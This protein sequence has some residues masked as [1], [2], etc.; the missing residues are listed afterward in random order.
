ME[1]QD[2]FTKTYDWA[3]E[4]FGCERASVYCVVARYQSMRDG[5]CHASGE[6]MRRKAGLPART[7]WRHLRWLK[8]AGAIMDTTPSWIGKPHWLEVVDEVEY[9]RAKSGWKPRSYV[10]E[11]SETYAMVA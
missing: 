6:T 11:E 3:T 5:A 4:E 1:Y 2:T 7:F 9:K 10:E 8:D